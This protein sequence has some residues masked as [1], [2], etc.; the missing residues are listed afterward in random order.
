MGELELMFAELVR[1][2][3]AT[4]RGK[5]IEFYEIGSLPWADHV[6]T[7]EPAD[8]E[9]SAKVVAKSNHSY[10]CRVVAAS[11]APGVQKDIPELID[12]LMPLPGEL[13]GELYEVADRVNGLGEKF[14]KLQ[15]KA[16]PVV[17][18]PAD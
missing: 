8:Q 2:E 15:G 5:D 11:I 12:E 7:D 13:V 16:P 4:I 1:K 6:M 17:D 18:T 10:M 14:E 9:R 3:T